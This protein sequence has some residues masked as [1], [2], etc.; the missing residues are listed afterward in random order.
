MKELPKQPDLIVATAKG[1]EQI[2][3]QDI[4]G[5]ETTL[6]Q[7]FKESILFKSFEAKKVLTPREALRLAYPR[8]SI[9]Q[10]TRPFTKTTIRAEKEFQILYEPA[11]LK[12]GELVPTKPRAKRYAKPSLPLLEGKAPKQIG[13]TYKLGG[14]KE[15]LRAKAGARELVVI[16]KVPSGQIEKKL[17]DIKPLIEIID[18]KAGRKISIIGKKLI[19]KKLSLK[20]LKPKERVEYKEVESG[21]QQLLQLLKPQKQKA[22]QFQLQRAEEKLLK[23]TA[24]QY[25]PSKQKLYVLQG[26]RYRPQTFKETLATGN[27]FAALKRA[28]LVG[29]MKSPLQKAFQQQFAKSKV[30][31]Q[32]MQSV[33]Q[34][35]ALK[36]MQMPK[37]AVVQ[38]PMQIVK[39]LP[40]QKPAQVPSQIPIQA[41][42]QKP[43]QDI[44][45]R[46][47]PKQPNK[48][49][50]RLFLRPAI[51]RMKIP[52]EYRFPKEKKYLKKKRG[53]GIG[54][55]YYYRAFK[56]PD[57]AQIAGFGKPKKLKF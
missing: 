40:F 29:L 28:G 34:I 11:E 50:S 46:A 17:F 10:L 54:F 1:F 30:R 33:F 12:F 38:K 52:R 14:F 51:P 9:I 21:Q 42:A 36:P 55:G 31:Q 57:L 19:T 5:K 2:K 8:E 4:L 26:L 44:L 37:Q 32:A 45:E 49:R 15:L 35:P 6:P 43:A 56:F 7:P 20:Q 27:I 16:Q 41:P 3:A 24:K 48:F 22:K 39:Q 18:I 53:L 23:A 13:V 25:Q 47:F